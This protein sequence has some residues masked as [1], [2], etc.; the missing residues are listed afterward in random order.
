MMM[1][2]F[3]IFL[4][5]FLLANFS[6]AQFNDSRSLTSLEEKLKVNHEEMLVNP[7]KA[8]NEIEFLLE[9]AIKINDK[10]S[11]LALLSRRC[12]YFVRKNDLKNAIDA[13]QSLEKKSVEYKDF[14]YQGYAHQWLIEIY[15]FSN[16]PERA[17]SEFE[18]SL[19]LFAK[20]EGKPDR[21]NNSIAHSY[22]K[23]ATVYETKKDFA[24]AKNML[25]HTHKYF[26]K[27][28][29]EDRRNRALFYN[30]SN[31]GIVSFELKNLDS[32][33]YFIE[34]SLSLSNPKSKVTLAQF[35]NYL[36][37][38]QIKQ[39]KGEISEALESYKLAEKLDSTISSGTLEKELLYKGLYDSYTSM[40]SIKIASVYLNKYKNIQIEK[41]KNKN[42][43]LHKIID[44][45]LLKDKSYTVHIAIASGILLLI[46][47][48]FLVITIRKN[49]LLANQ[50]KAEELYLDE[51]KP[52]ILEE[53]QVY[54][55]L[56]E[57][58][59]N[60]NKSFIIA[61]HDKFPDFYDKLI[62]I[63]P[64][65]VESEIEFCA[66]LKLKL[67][68]KEIAQIQNIEPKTVKNKKNRIRKRLNIS[69]EQELY[70]FFNQI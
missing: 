19:E 70:Y 17:I 54:T 11:E 44:E 32:S 24:T 50:E 57:M 49:K 46:M 1:K 31:L 26:N 66:F 35:R 43:S 41:E 6:F 9:E 13:V 4:Y 12:W 68:T 39:K 27:L 16:L 69:A 10:E 53:Q 52:S 51:N 22:M 58:A 55:Q 64:K 3:L 14:Y 18:K 45:E 2:Q 33:E 7:E 56:I 34:K 67:S 28:Q 29:D 20:A 30:Y 59:K 42:N 36:F 38:G 48:V 40:D 65:L 37:L 8:F 23:V 5:A 15:A 61:F 63:N 47:S 60:D 25:L 21:I 62:Q